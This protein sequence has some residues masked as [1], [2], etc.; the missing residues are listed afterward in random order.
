[1]NPVPGRAAGNIAAVR[2]GSRTRWAVL[3][4]AILAAGCSSGGSKAAGPTTTTGRT[5]VPTGPT[6]PATTA[7]STLSTTTTTTSSLDR[8]VMASAGGLTITLAVTPIK[9]KGSK[10]IAFNLSAQEGE[11]HG[12]LEYQLFYGDGK[13]D[14][15]PAPQYCV[16]AASVA[17]STWTLTHHYA[18]PG[19]Y[20]VVLTAWANCTR[21]RARTQAV[22]VTIT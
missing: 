19:T 5:V 8:T 22:A 14:Q 15:N 18:A 6:G 7:G 20:M 21:D 2:G 1:V 13:T 17:H 9:S 3:A 16:T 4:V 12:A 11:A 10:P